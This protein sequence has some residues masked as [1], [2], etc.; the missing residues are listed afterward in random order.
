MVIK[1]NKQ[2][3]EIAK[4]EVKL[5]NGSEKS[6][7]S[8]ESWKAGYNYARVIIAKIMVN[9]FSGEF[10]DKIQEMTEVELEEIDLNDL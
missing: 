2:F 10:I 6:A 9:D 4:Q 7:E 1:N 8:I 3:T 5:L